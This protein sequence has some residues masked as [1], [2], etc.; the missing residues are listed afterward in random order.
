MYAKK[1]NEDFQTMNPFTFIPQRLRDIITGDVDVK[2][3]YTELDEN[4][5]VAII[6]ISGIL[7]HSMPLL[8][9]L[10]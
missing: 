6:D 2:F 1:K 4:G 8:L 9:L 3:P 10:L 7:D 5:I